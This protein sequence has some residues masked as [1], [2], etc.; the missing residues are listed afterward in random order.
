MLTQFLDGYP[1]YYANLNLVPK[2][3]YCACRENDMY[4]KTGA[5]SGNAATCNSAAQAALGPSGTPRTACEIIADARI[6]FFG[7]L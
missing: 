3:C 7:V 4:G 2:E 6:T 5:F 1:H